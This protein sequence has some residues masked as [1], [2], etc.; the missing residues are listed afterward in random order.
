MHDLLPDFY[1]VE[2]LCVVL[3]RED[4][5]VAAS[6]L[7]LVLVQQL[8]LLLRVLRFYLIRLFEPIQHS[9]LLLVISIV[10]LP[11]FLVL[12]HFEHFEGVSEQRDLDAL[13]ERRVCVEGG[14]L[15]HFQQPGLGLRVQQ[16]IES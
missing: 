5:F 15:V 14:R 16:N 10:Q 7:L 13:V 6:V 4:A 2:A 3:R 1:V 11:G 12:R 8:S 9:L